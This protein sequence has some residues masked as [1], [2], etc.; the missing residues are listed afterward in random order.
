MN[1]LVANA[2]SVRGENAWRIAAQVAVGA[3][4]DGRVERDEHRAA[5]Q[6]GLPGDAARRREE[7]QQQAHLGVDRA[8]REE[9]RCARARQHGVHCDR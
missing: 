7:R 4:G 6:S 8:A 5:L 1:S 3:A 2:A 9:P